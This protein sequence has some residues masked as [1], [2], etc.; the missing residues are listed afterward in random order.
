MRAILIP[1]NPGDPVEGIQLRSDT[2]TNTIIDIRDRL[3]DYFEII[4]PTQLHG[5][6]SEEGGGWTRYPTVAMVVTE[7]GWKR[8]LGLN[9]RA[10]CF[11]DGDIVG[12]AILLT[13][14]HI[15][16]AG[17]L[18]SLLDEVTVDRVMEK[19]KELSTR[20]TPDDQET[21]G[22]DVEPR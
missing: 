19:I 18:T 6:L 7:D 17:D 2:Y 11:Y 14:V 22:Q 5:L 8:G 20:P 4:L 1:A 12:D 9:Q 21:V 15:D 10:S 3:G 16:G 13:E